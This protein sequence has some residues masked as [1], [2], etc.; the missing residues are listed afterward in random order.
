MQLFVTVVSFEYKMGIF[1]YAF[2]ERLAE[3]LNVKF[4]SLIIESLVAFM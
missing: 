2:P 3:S 1:Q 4:Q